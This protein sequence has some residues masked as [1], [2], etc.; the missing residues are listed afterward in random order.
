V[1]A[2]TFGTLI[3]N[4]VVKFIANWFTFFARSNSL[5]RFN[6]VRLG[7]GGSL[8]DGPFHSAFI[9]GSV[10]AFGFTGSA[11]DAIVSNHYGHEEVS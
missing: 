9:D 3:G 7:D 5:S 1:T 11:V 6:G 4:D 8:I 2:D 10:R